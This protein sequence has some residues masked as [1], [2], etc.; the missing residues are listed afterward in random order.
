[1]GWTGIVLDPF[2]EA[3]SSSDVYTHVL[4]RGGRGV[5]SPADGLDDFITLL[6]TLLRVE[7]L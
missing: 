7:L 4:D 3:G 2:A 1:M 6:D 5:Y